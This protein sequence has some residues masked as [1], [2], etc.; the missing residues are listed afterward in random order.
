MVLQYFLLHLIPFYV[1][2]LFF[3]NKI[4]LLQALSPPPPPTR[5]DKKKVLAFPPYNG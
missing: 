1:D 2:S 4:L 3:Q 5:D